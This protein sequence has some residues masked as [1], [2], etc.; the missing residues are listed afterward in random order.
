MNTIAQVR[1]RDFP[2]PPRKFQPAGIVEWADLS[3]I[4]PPFLRSEPRRRGRRAEGT[5]YERKVHAHFSDEF[6]DYYLPSPW[7]HFRASGSERERWC[8]PDAL[9]FQPLHRILTIVEVKLQHTSDA[10]W[11]TN[12]LYSPVVSRVFPPELWTYNIVE[13]VKWFD[14]SVRFPWHYQKCSH[15]LTLPINTFGIHICRL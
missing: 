14:P 5:R 1:T 10:W 6:G 8:Q 9:L 4:P 2:P 12:Q 3:T 13:V 15:I 11:Q 7:F